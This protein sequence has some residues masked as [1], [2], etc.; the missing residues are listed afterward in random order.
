MASLGPPNAAEQSTVAERFRRREACCWGE[1][2]DDG[3][4]SRGLALMTGAENGANST[5]TK[6]SFEE[7]I[8]D[9]HA[10]GD[11]I[12]E[13]GGQRRK[14]DKEEATVRNMILARDSAF[15]IV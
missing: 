8:N 1:G 5:I 3:E 6:S 9:S 15:V 13:V 7:P 4:T 10:R 12:Y 14:K 2:C 11:Y